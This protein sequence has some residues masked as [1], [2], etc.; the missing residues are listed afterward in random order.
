MKKIVMEEPG[1]S[2]IVEVE[3]PKIN[4]NQLLVKVRYTGIC[5]SELYP[6]SVAQAGQTFG[7]EPMGTVVEV[8]KNVKGFQVGDRVSGLGGGYAEYIVM[9]PIITVHIPD[10]VA[11]EDAVVEP[12]SC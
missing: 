6:W 10:N 1:K 9:D 11:D 5:H 12:H 8:G 3:I 4:E 2:K 7:H